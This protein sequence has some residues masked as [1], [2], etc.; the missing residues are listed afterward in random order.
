MED[1]CHR[2][3]NPEPNDPSPG[4]VAVELSRYALLIQ[5]SLP[6]LY[7]LVL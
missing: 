1:Q 2:D 4:I 6:V 3:L 5:P 7:F